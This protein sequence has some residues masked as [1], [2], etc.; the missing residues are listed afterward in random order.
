MDLII[1]EGLDITID[2]SEIAMMKGL[3]IDN[4][5]YIPA[6]PDKHITEQGGLPYF[7]HTEITL[8]CGEKVI[9]ELPYSQLVL[10]IKKWMTINGG[11][12]KQGESDGN[13]EVES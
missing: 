12:N 6:I 1:L 11:M 10:V 8:K 4:P 13:S 3:K 2:L 7:Q 9:I 5:L